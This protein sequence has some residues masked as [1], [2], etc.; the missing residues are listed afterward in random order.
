MKTNKQNNRLPIFESIGSAAS[1]LGVPVSVIRAAKA[2][3][4]AAFLPGNR[5]SAEVL[6]PY[7]FQ[8]MPVL[9]GLAGGRS[10][11]MTRKLTAE[12]VRIERE[13]RIAAGE[14]IT[15]EEAATLYGK[16]VSALV[17]KLEAIPSL[18][19]GITFEQRQ[20]LVGEIE[21]RKAEARAAK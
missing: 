18:V 15:V 17:Q 19:P 6:V 21:Q 13:N 7:L 8:N 2:N 10:D 11:A 3:G 12:S 14:I 1:V 4:C 16:K 20:I 9:A 5:I